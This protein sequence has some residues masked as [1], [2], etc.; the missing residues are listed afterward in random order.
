VREVERG[1]LDELALRPNALEENHHL[2]LEEDHR[3]DASSAA[4][5]VQVA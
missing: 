1:G 5:R 3:V 4:I 2:Q